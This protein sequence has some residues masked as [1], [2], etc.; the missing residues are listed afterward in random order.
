MGAKSSDSPSVQE[1][2]KQLKGPKGDKE[3]IHKEPLEKKYSPIKRKNDDIEPITKPDPSAMTEPSQSCHPIENLEETDIQGIISKKISDEKPQP[4]QD[5]ERTK[6]KPE[7]KPIEQIEVEE[8]PL[9]RLQ[10]LENAKPVEKDESEPEEEF[11]SSLPIYD[12]PI[13]REK[14][15]LEH[16][17]TPEKV[18]QQKK[19]PVVDEPSP[20]W[21]RLKKKTETEEDPKKMILGMGDIPDDTLHD[22]LKLKKKQ[23]SPLEQVKDLTK[24]NP[25]DPAK[26]GET[27]FE[28]T[29]DN[30]QKPKT[31]PKKWGRG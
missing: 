22:D 19:K 14:T 4:K 11:V 2:T 8:S 27:P 18:Q 1:P 9:E 3:N 6:L 31:M 5:P 23:K 17:D 16:Y 13:K 20:D 7:L 12:L 28:E 24:L 25:V 10:R 15:D 30:S 21:D 29:T 26:V